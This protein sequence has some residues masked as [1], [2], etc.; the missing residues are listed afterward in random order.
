LHGKSSIEQKGRW[1][2]GEK[3]R[4]LTG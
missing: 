4:R 2:E 3:G 1:G